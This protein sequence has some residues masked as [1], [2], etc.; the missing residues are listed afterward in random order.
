MV[1]AIT[2]T[3]QMWVMVV[4]ISNISAHTMPTP[5][6]CQTWH[7]LT[8]VL[9][10]LNGDNLE[11]HLVLL[12][13]GF[14]YQFGDL[15]T[16]HTQL[17]SF[18]LCGFRSTKSLMVQSMNDFLGR[19]FLS[20]DPWCNNFLLSCGSRWPCIDSLF[21]Q[22]SSHQNVSCNTNPLHWVVLGVYSFFCVFNQ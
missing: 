16:C 20:P 12:L 11:K 6:C 19:S 13:I 2:F 1:I 3:L 7:V 4:M 22:F 8:Q 5:L 9:S 17:S 18:W 10:L 21:W 15:M 14:H